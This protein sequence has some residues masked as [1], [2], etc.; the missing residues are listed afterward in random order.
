VA[1]DDDTL[2]HLSNY[3]WLN[4]RRRIIDY[5]KKFN[6][7]MVVKKGQ[8]FLEYGEELTNVY[9]LEDGLLGI[10]SLG[11]NGKQRTLGIL[12]PGGIYGI[13]DVVMGFE[14]P[15]YEVNAYQDTTLFYISKKQ[16]LEGI[17]CDPMLAF[18]YMECLCD[19][20]AVLN[21]SVES[22][23]FY[24]PKQQLLLFLR[25][26]CKLNHI[27]DYG[28]YRAQYSF[29]HQEIADIIGS[30]R[31]NVTMHLNNLKKS[32]LIKITRRQIYFCKDFET[33]IQS[34][35]RHYGLRNC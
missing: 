28:W 30:T 22:S 13:I 4:T 8:V 31:E 11:L 34:E 26:L 25:N 1:K 9:C 14:S 17:I 19:I 24:S 27:E 33:R 12:R 2:S 3:P 18:A 15:Q 29:S 32:G 20:I 5:I 21:D 23:S 6:Q 7:R 35:F 16:T 10:R